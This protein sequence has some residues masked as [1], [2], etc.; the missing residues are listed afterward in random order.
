MGCSS[1]EGGKTMK[2]S[3]LMLLGCA[4]LL[5]FTGCNP[6][7]CSDGCYNDPIASASAVDFIYE[8]DFLAYSS[9][10]SYFWD[11]ILND[12]FVSF[13]GIG[14]YGMVRVRIYDDFKILIFDEIY[15][16]NGGTLRSKSISSFGISG[17]WEVQ[18][19][20]SNVDGFIQVILD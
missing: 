18:I 19:D 9:S 15:F 5:T 2:F 11:T 17:L 4:L 16:G 12:A 6:P 10:E 20:S 1:G 7:R 3:F 13:E 8:G 14:F